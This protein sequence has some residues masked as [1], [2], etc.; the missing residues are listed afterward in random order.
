[1]FSDSEDSEAKPIKKFEVKHGKTTL[2][3][4]DGSRDTVEGSG[5]KVKNSK[6]YVG[7]Y[8]DNLPR[9]KLIWRVCSSHFYCLISLGFRI[10]I[11]REN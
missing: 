7:V 8:S 3:R 1:M 10:Q 2:I 4:A 6:I 5:I 9:F 11:T